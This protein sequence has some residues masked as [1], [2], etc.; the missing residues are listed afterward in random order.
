M[1]LKYRQINT[2][3]NLHITKKIKLIIINFLI[4]IWKVFIWNDYIYQ[5][6]IIISIYF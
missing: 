2:N 5:F 6:F 4:I 1:N 3:Y